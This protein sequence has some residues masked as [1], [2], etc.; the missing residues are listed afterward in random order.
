M[1]GYQQWR[2]RQGLLCDKDHLI[3][4]SKGKVS[5][6]K[7]LS[8]Q[9]LV[10]SGDLVCEAT[11]PAVPSTQRTNPMSWQIQE[12]Q[13]KSPA[14]GCKVSAIIYSDQEPSKTKGHQDQREPRPKQARPTQPKSNQPRSKEP[15]PKIKQIVS[16]P[17]PK[18][19]WYQLSRTAQ[20]I[21]NWCNAQP[22]LTINQ[23]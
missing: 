7:H 11:K 14:K 9:Y 3:A 1:P 19:K 16:K 10:G 4:P 21:T 13:F 15:R 20:P 8:A 18:T 17:Q 2:P 12:W 23:D 5:E 22:R 6:V